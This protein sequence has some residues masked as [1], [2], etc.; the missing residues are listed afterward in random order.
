MQHKGYLV[1]IGG[2]EDKTREMRILRRTL[3]I[4]YAKNIVVIPSASGYPTD[5]G[6]KYYHVF[7]DLGA[8]NVKIFDIR[9][10]HEADSSEYLKQINYADMVFFTGGDQVKL[11]DTLLGTKLL[12]KIK[13]LFKDGV[14][15][16]GTSAG[17]AAAGNLMIFDGD[18]KGFLKGMVKYS[19]GFGFIKNI[20]I[21]THFNKRERLLRL[22]EFLISGNSSRGIGLGEDTAIIINPVKQ[23]EVI[24]SGIVT[25]LNSSR[26]TYS[27]YETALNN[28]RL[29]TNGI[30][31]GFLQ[32][33]AVFNMQYWSV[34]NE[35]TEKEIYSNNYSRL[36]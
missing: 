5:T 21:D 35:A 33:G 30:N 4:N 8:D 16:A 17:A 10:K 31:I 20:T 34:N 12:R 15:I 27:N 9:R 2:A 23:F 18:R 32:D 14:T 3:E 28:D 24:G 7:R 29:N 11:A 13:R 22:T 26:Y 25:L 36:N 19:E 1:L 6:K